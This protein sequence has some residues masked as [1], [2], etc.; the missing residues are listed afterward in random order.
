MNPRRCRRR[1]RRRRPVRYRRANLNNPNKH[2]KS[3]YPF[4]SFTS[5]SQSGNQNDPNDGTGEVSLAATPQICRDLRASGLVAWSVAWFV[6]G[7]HLVHVT[8]DYP[9]GRLD[10]GQF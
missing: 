9:N 10:M 5:S 6:L 8:S 3:F 2:L 1:C 7:I 4:T